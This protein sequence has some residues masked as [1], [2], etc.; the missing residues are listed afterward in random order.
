MPHPFM[1]TEI[2][3]DVTMQKVDFANNKNSTFRLTYW[4][5]GRMEV[6]VGR[7]GTVPRTR[8]Y[9][10]VRAEIPAML[11]GMKEDDKYSYIQKRDAGQSKSTIQAI[12]GAAEVLEII[13]EEAKKHASSYLAVSLANISRGH[14]NMARRFMDNAIERY[15]S[16]DKDGAIAAVQGFYSAIP[17]K[18][19]ALIGAEQVTREFF[20]DLDVHE[21]RLAQLDAIISDDGVGLTELEDITDTEE[22]AGVI[23]RFLGISE[24]KKVLTVNIPF[25]AAAWNA[26][27]RGVKN[28]QSMYHGTSSG[29][30]QSILT[31]GL[32][33]PTFAANGSRLG[34]AIYFADNPKRS[35]SYLRGDHRFMLICDVAIGK[36]VEQPG[37]HDYTIEELRRLKV[38]S[39]RGTNSGS[40]MDE[41]TVYTTAQQR[42]KYLVVLG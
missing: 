31:A 28:I 19:P 9:A 18:L 39:V 40:G 21:Q 8:E 16:R 26:N 5:D 29:N 20:R 2:E 10:Q 17:T 7:V 32:A 1:S 33:I 24:V 4:A 13:E 36:F 6:T 23:S 42:T 11:I 3:V 41:W 14:L 34:R 25:E 22:G 35:M 12:G 37:L 30:I 15:R 38:D 27:K